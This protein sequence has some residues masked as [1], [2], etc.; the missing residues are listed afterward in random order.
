[1]VSR[2]IRPDPSTAGALV[3]TATLRNTAA[4]PQPWP[5]VVVELSDIDGNPV[6]MRRFRP[7]EYMPDPARRA[8]GITPGA[9]VAV[10]FEV[11]DPGKRAVNFQFGFE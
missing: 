10:A 4:F 3:I 1:L 5:L 8:A 6:A 7:T 9:T 2:D 11:A